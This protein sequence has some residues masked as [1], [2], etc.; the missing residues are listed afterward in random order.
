[1]VKNENNRIHM[2]RFG[3]F[4]TLLTVTYAKRLKILSDDNYDEE[5]LTYFDIT[6]LLPT[7]T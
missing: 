5:T 2:L 6:S 1:M 4:A 3:F 7:N